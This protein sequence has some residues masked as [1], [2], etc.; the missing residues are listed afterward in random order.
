MPDTSTFVFVSV[1][2]LVLTLTPGP[3]VLYIVARG[4]EGGRAAGF[5]SA[6]GI[7][8]GALVHILF[9]AV[10]LSALLASSAVAF[11]VVKWLGVA[12]LV[13]LGLSQLF[14]KEEPSAV[15]AVERR[16]LPGMFRKGVLVNVLN[17][18]VALFFLAFL[19][20]FLDPSTGP[21][22]LQILS[23]GLTVSVVGL[24]TDS[25]YALL[26]GAA[27]G[28]LKRR[29]ES[30]RFRRGRR[31]FSGGVYLALGAVT[32]VSGSGKD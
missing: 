8:V 19:P 20:Q 26:S 18:K 10:G 3:S 7:W 32:A 23:L 12:Y 14:G 29:Y 17:P 28:W 6:L 30:A 11:G 25:L 22:W 1:A 31:Y 5:T 4:V 16:S 2:S 21:A 9:A 13:W 15:A 27:G 24:C